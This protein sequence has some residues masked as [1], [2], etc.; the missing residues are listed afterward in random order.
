MSI[1]LPV[2]PSLTPCS[3]L[4][5]RTM[6]VSSKD[7]NK[8]QI[9]SWEHCISYKIV[10]EYLSATMATTKPC[11][12]HYLFWMLTAQTHLHI[13]ISSKR[14]NQGKEKWWKDSR[15]LERRQDSNSGSV[16]FYFH[17]IEQISAQKVQKEY[18]SI[19][20]KVGMVQTALLFSK[21][22]KHQIKS[23]VW[24]Y[25]TNH[26]KQSTCMVS[27]LLSSNYR[28]L[29]S[30][31]LGMDFPKFWICLFFLEPRNQGNPLCPY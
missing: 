4:S 5:H 19:S 27:S 25:F 18:T 17:G 16:A 21:G 29:S 6:H 22:C 2:A 23:E 13:P 14:E 10:L 3:L 24:T 12:K 26:N 20:V 1:I 9:W 11:G 31:T 28:S 30:W 8:L 7:L 15:T